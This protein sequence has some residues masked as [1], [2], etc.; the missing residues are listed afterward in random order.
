MNEE[1]REYNTQNWHD[2]K[3]YFLDSPDRYFEKGNPNYR[4]R[5]VSKNYN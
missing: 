5:W 3:K 4:Y 1:N 2:S